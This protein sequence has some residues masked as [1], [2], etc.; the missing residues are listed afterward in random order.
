MGG[1][2]VSGGQANGAGFVDDAAITA[3]IRSRIAD[4]RNLEARSID[5]ETRQGDVVLSGSSRTA[6]E[7]SAAES[8]AMKVRG[9]KT[10]RNEIAVRP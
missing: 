8:I 1:C 7:K 5:V 4:D 2:A 9:V 3:S 6:V 10:V